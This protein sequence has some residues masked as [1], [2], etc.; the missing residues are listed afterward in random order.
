MQINVE[1]LYRKYGPMV[2]RRCYFILKNK[3][4]AADAMQDVFV[5]LL[6]NQNRL[7][8]DYPSSLL[9]T[10]ATNICLNLIRS[11]KS[12]PETADE[13]LLQAIAGK[14]DVEKTTITA[15]LLERIFRDEQES[16]RAIA[17]MHFID[18]MTYE[19]IAGEVGLSVSGIRKR[20][21]TL[22]ERIEGVLYGSS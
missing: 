7:K 18:R 9:Y 11:A 22:S 13:E 10:M 2:Y 3:E 16:T 17:V 5:K 1:E 20:L 6:E 19:E 4:K 21:R 12:R 14:D 15:V 8:G